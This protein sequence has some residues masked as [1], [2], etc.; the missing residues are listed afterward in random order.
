MLPI[1][2]CVF[3]NIQTDH[4]ISTISKMLHIRI[5]LIYHR[6]DLKFESVFERNAFLNGHGYHTY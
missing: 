6:R 3:A 5:L 4:T 1:M 2:D